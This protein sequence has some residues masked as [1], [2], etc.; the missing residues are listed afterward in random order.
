MRD[1]EELQ[2][3]LDAKPPIT[4][5]DEDVRDIS[6][7]SFSVAGF[8]QSQQLEARVT[9]VE[10]EKEFLTVRIRS[11]EE[12]NRELLKYQKIQEEEIARI[13]REESDE[14]RLDMFNTNLLRRKSMMRIEKLSFASNNNESPRASQPSAG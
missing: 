3:K 1:V 7:I 12:K 8:H 14:K 13:G 5:I 11:L 4:L 6:M 10:R 9:E 2:E